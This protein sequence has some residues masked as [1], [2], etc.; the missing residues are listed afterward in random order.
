MRLEVH[1]KP[2]LL[3]VKARIIKIIKYSQIPQIIKASHKSIILH[4]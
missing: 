1:R 2:K 3:N 4:L